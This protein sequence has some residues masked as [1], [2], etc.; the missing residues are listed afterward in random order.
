MLELRY[1]SSWHVP[2]SVL[3][4]LRLHV[5]HE[6]RRGMRTR[7]RDV[8]EAAIH[9]LLDSGGLPALR[10]GPT[11]DIYDGERTVSLAVSLPHEDA[12]ELRR[13]ILVEEE[14]GIWWSTGQV[15]TVA[16]HRH[17]A[18]AGVDVLRATWNLSSEARQC[19]R[20]LSEG[21]DTTPSAILDEL[22]L[23]A[24]QGQ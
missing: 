16:L 7:T 21:A 24:A 23:T 4:D 12:V 13:Q 22:I 9:G 3:I 5:F 1:T 2:N 8:Q 15:M 19:L 6:R 18:A 10:S 20:D 17:L 14:E 11:L